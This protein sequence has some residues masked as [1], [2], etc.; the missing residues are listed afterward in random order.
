MSNASDLAHAPDERQVE[1]PSSWNHKS[2]LLK[3]KGCPGFRRTPNF[4]NPNLLLVVNGNTLVFLSL[5]IGAGGC[6]RTAL[7]VSRQ[8]NVGR[9]NNLVTFL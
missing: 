8:H 4:K 7:A 3:I 9:Q 5:G 1:I 6:N 2:Y